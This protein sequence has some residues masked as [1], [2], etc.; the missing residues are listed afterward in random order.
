LKSEHLEVKLNFN[1]IYSRCQQ[2][3]LS[4]E[5][6]MRIGM[7]AGVVLSG[8]DS[9]VK[10]QN[11]FGNHVIYASL[12]EPITTPGCAFA[13]EAYAACQATQADRH[14]FILEFVGATLLQ[15]DDSQDTNDTKRL[16]QKERNELNFC[17]L[18]N[19]KDA[20]QQRHEHKSKAAAVATQHSSTSIASN[21]LSP[22]A[23][24]ASQI[25]KLSL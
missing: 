23:K 21:N 8:Y 25:E 20:T 6:T 24:L 12:V 13:T 7:H 10:Q 15:N 11:Y 16:T 3:G 9:I 4:H 5:L 18:Y 2:L 14:E 22:I 19:L 17:N 1:N